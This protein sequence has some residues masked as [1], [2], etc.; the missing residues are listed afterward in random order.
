[1]SPSASH[2]LVLGDR[3]VTRHATFGALADPDI[4]VSCH[5]RLRGPY[6]GTGRVLRHVVPDA[7]DRRQGSGGHTG[8]SKWRLLD[9]SRH[10]SR[11]AR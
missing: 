10:R 6:S 7:H 5:A 8:G 11:S 4:V 9:V 2:L 3:R 1:M